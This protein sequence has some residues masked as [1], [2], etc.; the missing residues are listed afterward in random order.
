MVMLNL[1]S[2]NVVIS[3]VL[4]MFMER[5]VFR[6]CVVNEFLSR[7]QWKIVCIGG[8]QELKTVKSL[9]KSDMSRFLYFFKCPE[10]REM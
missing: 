5:H 8:A 10:F 9:C 6:R 2:L 7:F 4:A 1:E 3:M